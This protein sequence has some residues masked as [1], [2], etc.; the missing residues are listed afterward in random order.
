MLSTR[1]GIG[2]VFPS[3]R[4]TTLVDCHTEEAMHTQPTRRALVVGVIV[5]I[6]AL[7]TPQ[8]PAHALDQQAP[9]QS[10]GAASAP[11]I[12]DLFATVARRQPGFGGLYVDED[13]ATLYIYLRGGDVD[14]VVAG[15]KAVLGAEYPAQYRVQVRPAQFSFLELKHWHD[16]LAEQVVELPG[17]V[18]TDIDDATNRLMIGVEHPEAIAMVEQQVA[19]LN[20]P[21]AA[22]TIVATG[23]I[24]LAT[25]LRD[26]HRPLVGGLQIS[27]RSNTSEFLCTLGFIAIRRDVEGFV[28]NSH[29]SA[30]AGAVDTTVYYQ[31]ERADTNHIGEEAV[32]PN[33]RPCGPGNIAL[34]RRSDSNFSRLTGQASANLG[35][36]AR[37]RLNRQG[38]LCDTSPQFCA[39]D[40]ESTFRIV[41]EA[42]PPVVGRAVTKVGRSTGRTEGHVVRTGVLLN[43]PTGPRAFLPNQVLADYAS[44]PGDSGSPVISQRASDPD[45]N[46]IDSALQGITWGGITMPRVGDVSIFSPIHGVEADL[47]ALNTC[48][49]PREC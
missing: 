36:I 49:P 26:R 2:M 7:T 23:P 9:P 14:A 33:F 5:S 17:V 6:L 27:F 31:P 38:V 43:Y 29:C 42:A 19:E 12:D 25:S 46:P 8:L 47:G 18:L 28:T 40:G 32:D 41:R 35:F 13:Q 48:A 37:P 30:Q 16:R 24:E 4:K 34:C 39:W 10:S 15:L 44:A 11:T 20:I 21:A 22:V 3:S 45:R 1:L